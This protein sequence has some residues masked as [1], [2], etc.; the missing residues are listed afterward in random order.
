MDDDDDICK[1]LIELLEKESQ[2]PVFIEGISYSLFKVAELGK[3]STLNGEILHS[4]T[5]NLT[6]NTYSTYTHTYTHT[7]Q[8]QGSKEY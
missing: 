1:S 5:L 6:S 2:S 3:I 7:H 4:S 8:N